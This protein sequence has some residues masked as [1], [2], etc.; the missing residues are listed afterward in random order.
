MLDG[1]NY[2]KHYL[3][4]MTNNRVYFVTIGSLVIVYGDWTY[5]DDKIQVTGHQF[6]YSMIYQNQNSSSVTSSPVDNINGQ[7]E[8]RVCDKTCFMTQ[9][10][11]IKHLNKAWIVLP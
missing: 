3:H 2:R 8:T 5:G 1:K 9:A 6:M 11:D 7:G 10:S 4:V